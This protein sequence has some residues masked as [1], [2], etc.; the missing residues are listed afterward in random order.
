MREYQ[1]FQFTNETYMR[2]VLLFFSVLCFIQLFAQKTIKVNCTPN[3]NIKGVLC[4]DSAF[5]PCSRPGH[6]NKGVIANDS[7][8][9]IVSF[10]VFVTNL[11]GNDGFGEESENWGN[12]FSP[13]TR[14]ILT[15]ATEKSIVDFY[16]IKARSRTG[17]IFTLQPF[18][19]N[20]EKPK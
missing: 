3:T 10:K 7:T 15:R 2:I 9:V 18:T 6:C 16:C 1:I 17:E 19:F 14:S 13:E 5:C 11:K 20:P 4:P 8:F 12:M